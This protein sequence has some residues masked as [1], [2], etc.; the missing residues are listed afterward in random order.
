M[1]FL[2]TLLP[3]G[4]RL[5]EGDNSL[6]LRGCQTE[7]AHLAGHI[8]RILG[9]G[10][11]GAGYV[12]GVV[13]VDDVLKA[14]EVAIV[15]ISL[16]EA[17]VRSL[18]NI[19]KCRHLEFSE[20][21]FIDGAGAL[22]VFAKTQVNPGRT[23]RI[24]RDFRVE[25]IHRVFRHTDIVVCEVG[26]Q[27][28]AAG[29][30]GGAG[31]AAGALCFAVE[32]REPQRLLRGQPVAGPEVRVEPRV[33]WAHLCGALVVG[34]RAAD[35]LVRRHGVVEGVRAPHLHE[36]VRVGRLLHLVH[37]HA[38]ARVVLLQRVHEPLESLLGQRVSQRQAGGV[39]IPGHAACPAVR[40][41]KMQDGAVA[42]ICT[43]RWF[44][45]AE[46]TFDSALIRCAS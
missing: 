25:R 20:F 2:F 10:P 32:Q 5:Q 43:R 17:G 29:K 37:D 9:C 24:E 35:H 19:A 39:A 30:I 8:G 38:S 27:H 31:V 28:L 22:Q 13:K 26:E 16:H 1:T 42:A 4:Q 33:V 15:P 3:V 11:A 44:S 46:P 36:Q 34:N 23:Q 45:I 41:V 21:R 7:I 12:A 6:L 14:L 18:V 40:S